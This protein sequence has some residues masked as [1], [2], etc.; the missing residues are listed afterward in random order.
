[1]MLLQPL[2]SAEEK[3]VIY[4]LGE[5]NAEINIDTPEE[6]A[7][8]A[9]SLAKQARRNINIFT[10]DLDSVIYDNI[11][12][13]KAVSQLAISDTRTI[14]RILVHDSILAVKSDHK[15]LKLA[16]S[17]H[18]SIFIRNPSR[19]YQHIRC[20]YMV[21]DRLGYVYR[22]TP[23]QYNYD[24]SVNFMSPERAAT[25]DDNFMEVWEQ[26]TVDRHVRRMHI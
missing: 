1:M 15:L 12:F 9:V 8:A 19:L 3:P 4:K 2:P 26:S 20:S 14:I 17:M 22:G 13:V 24:A 7:N 5:T 6:N 16:R 18:D 10:Q 25:L 11:D 21:A 23:Q